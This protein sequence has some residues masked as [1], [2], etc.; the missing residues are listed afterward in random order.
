MRAAHLPFRGPGH[1]PLASPRSR[2]MRNLFS[3]TTR[4]PNRRLRSRRARHPKPDLE[5]LKAR[6]ALSVVT[7]HEPTDDIT[8]TPISISPI[9][10]AQVIGHFDWK[11][12]PT[13][14][15]D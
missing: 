5:A 4:L 3:S 10:P 2:S 6:I 11:T 12:Y 13:K 8:P 14:D 9:N 15:V 1:G 7:D